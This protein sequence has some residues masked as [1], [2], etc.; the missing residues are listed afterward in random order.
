[1]RDDVLLLM[2]AHC[3]ELLVGGLGPLFVAFG[4]PC[5]LQR[6][7]AGGIKIDGV[8]YLRNESLPST[9]PQRTGDEVLYASRCFR[10]CYQIADVCIISRIL[11]VLVIHFVQPIRQYAKR[12]NINCISPLPKHSS[13]LLI[14]VSLPRCP[15]DWRQIISRNRQMI[16]TFRLHLPA[17]FASLMKTY[18]LLR[19]L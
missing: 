14:N 8:K 10:A 2:P 1:M 13:L 6:P 19:R 16:A 9:V 7:V 5:L 18:N 3:S 12:T 17:I 15:I 11:D 4:L